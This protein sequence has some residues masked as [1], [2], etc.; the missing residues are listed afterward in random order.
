MKESEAVAATAE[1][2]PKSTGPIKAG[3]FSF[4]KA[5]AAANDAVVKPPKDRTWWQTNGPKLKELVELAYAELAEQ[6]KPILEP[7]G[8]SAVAVPVP[9]VQA[10]LT[11]FVRQADDRLGWD[12]PNMTE[13]TEDAFYA[14][15]VNRTVVALRQEGK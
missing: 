10:I 14:F 7:L 3:P 1:A 12:A 8:L 13:Q 11:Q 6:V 2:K 5:T 9:V 15:L 4:P